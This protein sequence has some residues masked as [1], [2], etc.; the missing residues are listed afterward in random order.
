MAILVVEDESDL[1]DLLC[2]ILRRAGH[3]AIPAYDGETALKLWRERNPELVLLDIGLP[4]ASGW[5]VCE[6]ISNESNTPVMIVSANDA[7]QDMVH[8]FDLG[9]EDYMSKPFSPKLLLARVRTLLRRS[10]MRAPAGGMDQCLS[11]GDLSIDA[12]WRTARCAS[13][14][15]HLTRLEHKVLQELALHSGQVVPHA[16]LIQRVWGYKGEASSHV[17]KGHI[18]SVRLKLA[19]IGSD[20]LIRIIPGVGYILDHRA[21]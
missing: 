19:E 1:S 21:A 15:V 7:E 4:K 20:A 6:I 14:N 5:E 3:D 2:F 12:R 18:R 8:G 11:I 13:R 16:D 10:E 17:V 9:A